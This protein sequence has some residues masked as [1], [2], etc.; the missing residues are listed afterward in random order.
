MIRCMDWQLS[1]LDPEAGGVSCKQVAALIDALVVAGMHW[2]TLD[3]LSCR[4][5][6]T[7]FCKALA[8]I[9]TAPITAVTST[10]TDILGVPVPLLLQNELKLM[11]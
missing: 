7:T 5:F 9:T 2:G 1:A 11:S 3:L 8:L 6:C 4:S 10:W